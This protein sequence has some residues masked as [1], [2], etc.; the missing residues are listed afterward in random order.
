MHQS[1]FPE[2]K[3]AASELAP[4]ATESEWEASRI[5]AAQHNSR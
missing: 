1:Y 3:R 5:G 4:Y 2:S